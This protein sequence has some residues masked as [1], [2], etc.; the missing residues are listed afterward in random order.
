MRVPFKDL[1]NR[2]GVGFDLSPYETCPWSSFDDEKGITCS[3]EV[4]MGPDGDEVEAELQMLYGMP[5]DGQPPLQQIMIALFK[6]VTGSP[7][8][9]EARA[10]KI[11]GK[12]NEGNMYNWEEKACSFFSACVQEIKMGR[13]PDIDD[14]LEKE[15][16]DKERFGA[17]QGG[18]GSKSPKIKPQALLGLKG[19]RGF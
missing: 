5:E 7:D 12:G 11:N 17:R 19:G 9:W 10:I 6:P 1:M 16:K 8:K 13:I 2:L 4:R 15:L 14:L 18:G 3:A